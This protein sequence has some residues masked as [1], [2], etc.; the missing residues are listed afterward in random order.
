MIVLAGWLAGCAAP[1]YAAIDVQALG[2]YTLGS[3][4]RLRVIVF[5]QDSLSNTYDVD[6]SGNISM[7]LVGLVEAAGL[8]TT[9]LGH[10]IQDRLRNGYL[11]EPHVSVEVEAYRPFFILGEVTTAGQYPFI[12]GMTVETAVAVAGGFTPRAYKESAE[13]TRI[14]NG[15]PVVATVPMIQPVSPG[16]T[17]TIRERFF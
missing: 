10:V 7:P 11:R 12:N 5:G 16:D 13:I 2:P 9:A 6:G 4:D 14:V 8:T 1:Y 3:G 15:V 17:V